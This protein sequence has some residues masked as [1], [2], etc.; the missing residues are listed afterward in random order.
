MNKVA[1]ASTGNTSSSLAAYASKAGI[2]CIVVIPSGKVAFGKLIQAIIYG[3]RIVRIRGNFDESLKIIRDLCNKYLI[4]LLNSL[5]PFRLEGQKTISYEIRDQMKTCLPDKI[6]VPV[7][8]AGNISAIWKGFKDLQRLDM[9]KKIPKLVG[10]QAEGAA[11]IAKS[12]MQGLNKV[13][14]VSN[15]ETLATAIRIGA[16]VNWKKAVAAVKESNGFLETVSDQEIVEA[17]SLLARQEGIFVEPAS[18]ASLAGLIKLT[19]RN[20]IEKDENIVCIATGHGLKD[21]E[22]VLKNFSEP[23]EANANLKS[24]EKLLDL[25]KAPL[26]QV[27][28]ILEC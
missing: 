13:S 9:I 27:N 20:R 14:F 1:C 16:P 12:L 4:Y 15:P 18:A 28:P 24:L 5:N 6:I 8:N 2:E 26:S 10:I 11:P 22:I 25:E 21:P 7:G 23:I 3:A 19:A 17:Q